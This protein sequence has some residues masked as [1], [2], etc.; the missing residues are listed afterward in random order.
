MVVSRSEYLLIEGLKIFGVSKGMAAAIFMTLRNDEQM[1]KM[2][3]YMT[4]HKEISEKA[5]LDAARQ[6]AS[7]EEWRG[8]ND[9]D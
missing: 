3:L 5:L 4:A 9:G 6:I 7:K 8:S 2:C 1:M